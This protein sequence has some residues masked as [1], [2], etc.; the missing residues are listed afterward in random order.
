MTQPERTVYPALG[1]YYR[2]QFGKDIHGTD[3]SFQE[4]SGLS[5]TMQTEEIAEGGENRFGDPGPVDRLHRAA[6]G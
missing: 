4:V 1:L 2:I 3:A 5:V 6:E